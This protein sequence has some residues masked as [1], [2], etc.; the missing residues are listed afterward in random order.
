MDDDSDDK[1]RR[2]LVVVSAAIVFGAWL[3]LPEKAIAARVFG[4]DASDVLQPWRLWAAALALLAYVL[5]RYRFAPE[6]T[7][8][9]QR[10]KNDFGLLARQK[11]DLNNIFIDQR[12]SVE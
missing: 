12:C 5:W 11:A 1:A 9:W 8:A 7:L 6:S 3:K 4:Q 2:N 10:L